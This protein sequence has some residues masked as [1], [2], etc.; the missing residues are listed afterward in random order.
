MLTDFDIE[1]MLA[2]LTDL[3]EDSDFEHLRWKA[4]LLELRRHRL[5]GRTHPPSHEELDRLHEAERSNSRAVV[6]ILMDGRD[7]RIEQLESLT[8]RGV[9]TAEELEKQN[10]KR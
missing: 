3:N 4:A 5:L 10:D 8:G 1:N 7:R 2:V 9:L 6:Q